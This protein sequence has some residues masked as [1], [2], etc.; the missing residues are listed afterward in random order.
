MLYFSMCCECLQLQTEKGSLEQENFCLQKDNKRLEQENK[1]LQE[2][3]KL[4]RLRKFGSKSEQSNPDQLEFDNLLQEHDE[5][6]TAEE[7][8]A[9][10]IEHIEYDRKKGKNKNLNG[11]VAIPDYLERRE[12][13]LDLT[14]EE[15]ICPVT[16]KEM[17]KIGEDVTEQLAVDP[18]KFYVNKYVRL[19]YASPDRRKGSKVGVKSAPLPE[20]PIERCKADVSLLASIIVN[21]YADHLPLY[22][23]EQIFKRHGIKIPANTMCD[24]VNNCAKTLRPLYNELKNSVLSH[25]YIHMDET[26]IDLLRK[27]KKKRQARLWV[28]RTGSGP[29]GIFFHFTESWENKHAKDLLKTFSG[30]LQTDG[31]SGYEKV[32]KRPDITLL[33]CLAHV[34]RKFRDAVKLGSKDAEYFVMLSNIL[35]RIEHRIAA[36]PDTVSDIEKLALR[37]KRANRVI[38][39][40]I[41]KLNTTNALPKSTLGKAITYAQNRKSIMRNYLNELRFKIDNN[42]AENSIRPITLGRRNYLFVG[43][44]R[45]GETAA[46]L[47]SLIS[48][49]K[50]NKVNPNKYL[51]DILGRIN[52]YPHKHISELLPQNWNP[53]QK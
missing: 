46:I 1:L 2:M 53:L 22:R 4:E 8:E 39:R 32:G 15:K 3:L 49:C 37:Q 20:G 13:L 7:K 23:Q 48:T 50:A 26:P 36:L 21:K 6:N 52:S 44:E 29:P 11:R 34:R 30:S 33:F 25:D 31:Y 10:A 18:P 17:I 51:E 45:G 28:G 19:K 16:G 42:A 5:L 38:D 9:E 27:G 41:K 24:W 47:M 14:P 43:S 35:Y 40:L 12:I